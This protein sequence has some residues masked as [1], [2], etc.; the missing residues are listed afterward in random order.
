MPLVEV[1]ASTELFDA[2]SLRPVDLA[3]T[4][5]RNRRLNGASN[6]LKSIP[7]CDLVVLECLTVV[8]ELAFEDQALFGD[9]YARGLHCK[10]AVPLRSAS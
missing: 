2:L 6:D 1:V 5:A 4:A 8:E 3:G 9:G 10:A 7:V